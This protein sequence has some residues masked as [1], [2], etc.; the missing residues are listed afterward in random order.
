MRKAAEPTA[1][2]NVLAPQS[3]LEPE[4]LRLTAECS[5]IEL[6][7]SKVAGLFYYTKAK[8]GCQTFRRA[9]SW[10]LRY[11]IEKA[12]HPHERSQSSQVSPVK[13]RLL[14]SLLITLTPPVISETPKTPPLRIQKT[15]PL[16]GVEGRLNHMSA[17]TRNQ[18]LFV[19]ALGNNSLEVVDWKT[20]K[21]VRSIK[22]FKGPQGVLYH[23]ETNRIVVTSRDDGTIK[24]L[25][26]SSYQILTTVN[27]F[28]NADNIR[29]DPTT[30][31]IVVGYGNGA[32]GSF[33]LNGKQLGEARLEV[34]PESFL[35]ERQGL[36]VFVNTP[37][38][39]S[40]TIVNRQTKAV[41]RTFPLSA[42]GSN[43]AL[44]LDEVNRRLFIACRK[45]PRILTLDASS[46]VQI[47]ERETVGDVA[48]IFYDAA[49]KRLYASGGD[50]AVDV[51]QQMSPNRYEPVAK[52]PTAPGARTSLFVAD[53]NLYF[54]AVPHRGTQQP[55]IR[56]FEVGN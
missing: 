55:E 12:S 37:T 29:Y 50:G 24:F 45:P 44:A 38:S 35:L 39:K 7:R 17:D 52:I 40:I 42:V 54:V 49:R 18:R 8:H 22:D 33:D 36:R 46:G 5:T 25:D 16:P 34:H 26:G 48:D 47:D 4:T 13:F 19:A 27:K 3:G 10:C 1:R 51:I 23:P 11:R 21:V 14:V 56:V 53:A 28:T 43:S 41:T 32:L 6:L 31:T 9:F 2:E 30:K 20:G 15:I